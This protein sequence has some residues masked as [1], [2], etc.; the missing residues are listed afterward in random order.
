MQ[1]ISFSS[2]ATIYG[3][4]EKTPTSEDAKINPLNPYGNTKAAVEKLLFDVAECKPDSGVIQKSSCS[5]W[6]IARLR[7][8]NPAGAHQSG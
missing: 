1:N 3:D 4:S 2:S 7:Y 8:F 5:G 6:R